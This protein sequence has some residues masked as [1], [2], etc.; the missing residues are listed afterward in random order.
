M[1]FFQP[2]EQKK[3]HGFIDASVDNYSDILTRASNKPGLIPEHNIAN[4]RYIIDHL[5]VPN[6]RHGVLQL[7]K[8]ALRSGDY[9]PIFP[10]V[11]GEAV[12]IP[13]ASI[14]SLHPFQREKALRHFSNQGIGLSQ[15]DFDVDTDLEH[16]NHRVTIS[17]GESGF[18][19]SAQTRLHVPGIKTKNTIRYIIGRPHI[20]LGM[21]DPEDEIKHITRKNPDIVAHEFTHVTQKLIKPVARYDTYGSIEDSSLREELEAYRYQELL[22]NVMRQLDYSRVDGEPSS[23]SIADN[24]TPSSAVY[25][26][27]NYRREINQN[28]KDKLFPD[29]KLRKKFLELGLDIYN[30]LPNDSPRHTSMY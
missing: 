27:N 28:R 14:Q 18:V 5:T 21:N 17:P 4:D 29:G 2:S 24:G 10:L 6:L 16:N 11:Y 9:I 23:E 1:V 20:F 19:E 12:T 22:L 25:L 15:F 26:I 3:R 8:R 30:A 7:S 13:A